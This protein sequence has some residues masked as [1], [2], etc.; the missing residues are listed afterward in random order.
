M[1]EGDSL[2][3]DRII[4]VQGQCDDSFIEDRVSQDVDQEDFPLGNGE[5]EEVDGDFVGRGVKDRGHSEMEGACL[6]ECLISST[7]QSSPHCYQIVLRSLCNQ[8]SSSAHSSVV[9]GHVE[10][11]TLGSSTSDDE[12]S[13]RLKSH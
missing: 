12:K 6:V 8:I 4:M 7:S 11:L 5:A 10:F 13:V 3:K 1:E 2:G 9:Q